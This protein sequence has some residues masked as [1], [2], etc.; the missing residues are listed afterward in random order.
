MIYLIEFT[1]CSILRSLTLMYTYQIQCG[2]IK[3]TRRKI[4]EK[5]CR[6]LIVPMMFGV[7]K[8]KM[9]VKRKKIFPII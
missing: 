9:F 2:L 8:I 7:K 4:V 5:P 3:T 6:I 1:F